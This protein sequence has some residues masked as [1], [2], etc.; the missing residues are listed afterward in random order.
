MTAQAQAEL[1]RAIDEYESLVKVEKEQ[2]AII[3]RL[4]KS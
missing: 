3:E 1:Q 4:S 2:Q